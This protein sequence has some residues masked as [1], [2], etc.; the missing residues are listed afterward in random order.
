[1]LTFGVEKHIRDIGKIMNTYIENITGNE[2]VV[3]RLF[4]ESCTQNEL[5]WHRDPED[6]VVIS[7]QKTNWMI[8]L[9]NSIP[10]SLN[11]ELFI[12]KETFHRLVKGTGDLRVLVKKK[13]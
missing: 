9:D 8:Q 5:L 4:K 11:F 7:L 10:V 3:E 12:P 6:R 1:M 2:S 13:L